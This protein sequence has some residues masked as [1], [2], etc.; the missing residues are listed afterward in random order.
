MNA[1][2]EYKAR[3]WQNST[4]SMTMSVKVGPERLDVLDL[5]LTDSAGQD[6]AA[7]WKLRSPV[8]NELMP[9]Y[10]FVRAVDFGTRLPVVP[11]WNPIPAT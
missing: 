9:D 5:R 2:M 1:T 4:E 10:D 3:L 11:V 6:L 7:T 8:Q